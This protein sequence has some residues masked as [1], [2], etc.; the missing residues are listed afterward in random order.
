[1]N[2][3]ILK[4]CTAALL[5]AA[6]LTMPLSALAAE[7]KDEPAAN[8]EETKQDKKMHEEIV[9]LRAELEEQIRMQNELLSVI[10]SMRAEQE[11]LISSK[12]P[13]S[14]Y[15]ANSNFLVMPKENE[16]GS[17]I[18]DAINAQG[19]S[20][21]VFTYSPSQLYRIYCA[22]NYLT[23]IQL[24]KGEQITFVG[25]GD[26]GKWMLDSSSV[27]GIP[28]LYLKPV[29][30]GAKTNL[31]I[32]TTHHSYQVL[33]E[34]GDWYNPIVKWAYGTEDMAENLQAA[35]KEYRM[36]QGQVTS[37]ENLNFSYRISGNADWKPSKVFDDGKRTWIK[38]DRREA[39]LP[40]LFVREKGHKGA[41][42]VNYHTKSD[43][44]IVDRIFDRAELRMGKDVVKI[45]AERR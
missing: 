42:V 11:A 7:V 33:C 16:P 4:N 27:D 17:Y 5:S 32:N 38:F 20:T 1:M 22:L 35:R 6:C 10:D 30:K 3:V 37:L 9:E 28:H 45:S 34:E 24:K 26:T 8:I 15:P 21:M 13:A 14:G 36:N 23:D 19:D 18:Q 40:V 31:I 43:C 12:E 41:I 44:I 25:G 29:A 39:K 2:K